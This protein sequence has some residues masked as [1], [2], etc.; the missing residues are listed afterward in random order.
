MAE[1]QLYFLKLK[2][3]FFKR[4]DITLLNRKLGADGVMFYLWL[5]CESLDHEGKLRFSD[6]EPYE[7]DD[8]AALSG[9]DQEKV[10]KTLLFL[11]RK[12][13]IT[14]DKSGTI[15]MND[16]ET[17]TAPDT[18]A[19]RSRRKREKQARM[20]RD[21]TTVTRNDTDATRERHDSDTE[22]TQS[23]EYRDKSIEYRDKSIDNIPP[24]PLLGD[25][26]AREVYIKQVVQD[27]VKYLNDRAGKNYLAK[28]ASTH[29]LIS[30]LL[31]QGYTPDDMRKVID[32]R[33]AEW[34]GTDKDRWLRP[35]TLFDPGK[36]EGYLNEDPTTR[37]KPVDAPKPPDGWEDIDQYFHKAG[38]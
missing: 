31:I 38:G 30:D 25:P 27:V 32:S 29:A 12:A 19:E 16:L 6:A 10:E 33:V 26:G 4:H 7:V 9:V 24:T 28:N 5:L 23:I 3:G 37:G 13:M 21:D 11:K 22:A 20:T 15:I 14:Q 1:G 2:R 17:F 35:A 34:S 18:D 8:L 36:F